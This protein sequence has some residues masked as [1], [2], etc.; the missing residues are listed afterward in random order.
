MNRHE[1]WGW[2]ETQLAGASVTGLVTS[3]VSKTAVEGVEL[4]QA[5]RADSDSESK[6]YGP[7]P[8]ER[9]RRRARERV[10]RILNIIDLVVSII[11]IPVAIELSSM[12]EIYP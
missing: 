8:R 5:Q 2:R 9:G 7:Q 12:R 3:L 6:T 10:K 1:P 11:P 4:V